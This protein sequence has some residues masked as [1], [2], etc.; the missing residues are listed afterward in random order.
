MKIT[1]VN[2]EDIV[3][4]RFNGYGLC[5]YL[6]QYFD[7]QCHMYVREKLS[8][9][10]FITPVWPGKRVRMCR[11]ATRAE[12]KLSLQNILY[13][14]ALIYRKYIKE[15]D[16]IHLQL[17]AMQY[18]SY[19]ELP[20]LAIKKPVVLSLHD[21]TAFSGCCSN[22]YNGTC[23]QW[24][25]GCDSCQ[26]Y[27]NGVFAL[28]RPTTAFHWKYK[29]WVWN[30]VRPDVIVASQWLMDRVNRSPMFEKCRKHLVPF[31]LNLKIFR[32][33]AGSEKAKL[34]YKLGIPQN[35]FVIIFRAYNS[36]YKGLEAIRQAIR[37]LP[38][39]LSKNIT[40]ITMNGCG[41]L[42]EFIGRSHILEYDTV[43]REQDMADLFRASDLFLMPSVQETF[44]MMAIESMACGVASIVST[45]TPLPEV[46]RAPQAALTI[47]AGDAPVL[48]QAMT[49]MINDA[50]MRCK[51]A[52]R[53]RELAVDLYDFRRYA[54]SMREI[55]QARITEAA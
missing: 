47:P 22:P 29:K 33:A 40:F 50:E 21:F 23:E 32:P 54:R 42:N 14:P 24:E 46:T 55:Y 16:I 41:F 30:K 37:M 6:N 5:K 39:G 13:P 15:A 34:R 51:M 12:Q 2:C 31:G 8:N 45:N 7:D 38:E 53:A 44:G 26:D 11:L 18:L 36:P 35:N 27:S 4:Q 49:N 48:C 43:A 28:R 9:A 20:L 17:I 3:G 10:S 52:H 1:Y 19:W 25:T